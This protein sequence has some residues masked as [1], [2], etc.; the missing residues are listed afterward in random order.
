M[1]IVTNQRSFHGGPPFLKYNMILRNILSV[2]LMVTVC[3]ILE[4]KEEP[5][6]G[7]ATHV[8]PHPSGIDHEMKL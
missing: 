5:K 4:R 7:F 6:V 1:G 8:S 2:V 3:T